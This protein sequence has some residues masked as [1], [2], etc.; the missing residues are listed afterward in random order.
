MVDHAN[1]AEALAEPDEIVGGDGRAVRPFEAQ[2]AFLE[3]HRP[4]C[5][6]DHRLEG[7]LEPLLVQ[8][9]HQLAR[10]RRV[11]P[12]SRL[13]FGR[14]RVDDEMAVAPPAG[15]M[16]TLLGVGHRLAHG[17]SVARQADAADRHR[18]SHRAGF[19]GDDVPPDRGVEAFGGRAHVVL[20]AIAQNDAELVAGIAAD[21]IAVAQFRPDPP[22][23]GRK[24]LVGSIEI[25]GLV[26]GAEIVHRD[27]EEGDRTAQPLGGVERLAESGDQMATIEEAGQFVVARQEGAALLALGAF[28]DHPHHA[29]GADRP[30]G[31]A[32]IP[33]SRILEDDAAARA[34]GP[35]IE[36]VLNLVEDACP[37]VGTPPN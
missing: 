33:A 10:Q 22:P 4:R 23:D 12:L 25:V 1:E 24:H 28:V 16:E 15:L 31:V 8:G 9:R 19:R 36:G 14:R 17:A 34:V 29:A 35:R 32:G 11:A 7:E 6:I 26:D 2:Q 27:D 37:D 21:G 13:A 30:P 5:E 20:V 3:D 18:G